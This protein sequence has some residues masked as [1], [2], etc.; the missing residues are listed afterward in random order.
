MVSLGSSIILSNRR[1]RIARHETHQDLEATRCV[2][3]S[4]TPRAWRWDSAQ[5]TFL[6]S[7][8]RCLRFRTRPKRPSWLIDLP[9]S[10]LLVSDRPVPASK[11]F[12]HVC[13]AVRHSGTATKENGGIF[14]LCPA[15]YGERQRGT[16]RIHEGDG[17]VLSHPNRALPSLTSIGGCLQP[18][19]CS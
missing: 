12:G 6:W 16:G 15:R 7:P 10:P 18:N 13:K 9:R 3:R 2:P 1:T 14:F 17:L 8:D 11:R 5:R 19:L 4:P